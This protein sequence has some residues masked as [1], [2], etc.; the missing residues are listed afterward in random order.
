MNCPR[1]CSDVE[2]Q[3]ARGLAH[4]CGAKPQVNRAI[5]DDFEKN[6][7]FSP[8]AQACDDQGIFHP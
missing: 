2:A 8:S 5:V 3:A 4:S 7:V 6:N 1:A